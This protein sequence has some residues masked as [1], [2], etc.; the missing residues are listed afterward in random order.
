[1]QCSRPLLASA[2]GIV[3]VPA[4]RSSIASVRLKH[5]FCGGPTIP[6]SRIIGETSSR[7]H[8]ANS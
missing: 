8:D 1:M 4:F 5:T 6:A 2:A 3:I 7:N